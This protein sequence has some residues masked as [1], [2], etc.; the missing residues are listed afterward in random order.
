MVMEC[1]TASAVSAPAPH[2]LA[3]PSPRMIAVMVLLALTWGAS[4][5]AADSTATDIGCTEESTE[6]CRIDSRSFRPKDSAGLKNDTWYLVGAQVASL[7]A[8]YVL[9]EAVSGWNEEQKDN[10]SGEKWLENVQRPVIDKDEFYINYLLH[11]Y[12]GAAYYVRAR[13]RGYDGRESFWYS[14]LMS[15]MYEFGAEALFEEPSI[16]DLIVTPVF[17]AWLGSYFM[18]L[19]ESIEDRAFSRGF[20]TRTETTLL[21]LTDPLGTINVGLDRLLGRQSR[22]NLRPMAGSPAGLATYSMGRTHHSNLM[23]RVAGLP[24]LLRLP[25]PAS[26]VHP[27]AGHNTRFLGL[28]F[29]LTW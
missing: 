5:Q 12:W 1:I 19:R 14:A 18:G 25:G 6:D 27:Q 9:P 26:S 10:Y 23:A 11:P 28:Q 3:S 2:S 29:S 13:E 22:M 21:V 24:A 16:Q 4:S 7:A 8:L 20:R 15:A 17:G